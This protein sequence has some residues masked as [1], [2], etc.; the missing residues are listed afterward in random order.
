MKQLISIALLFFIISS[1]SLI[2]KDAVIIDHNCTDLDKIPSEFI[3]KSKNGF[4]LGYGHTSHGSQIVSGMNLLKDFDDLYSFN[5]GSGSLFLQDYISD[6]DY[7]ARD[8]G[9]PNFS[10]WAGSTFNILSDSNN[11]LNMIMWSWCGQVSGASKENID[12]YLSQ[13]EDLEEKFPE[14]TFVYMTG[15]L[16][17]SGLKG[18]LHQ[19]NEIIRKFCRDNKKV[20]FDF[21]D[22]ESYDPD[23]NYFLDKGANDACNYNGGNWAV[24]WCNG[25]PDK[26]EDCSCSHSHCLNCQQKGKAF[27]WM[28]ARVAGWDGGKTSFV[29][30]DT[31]NTDKLYLEQNVPNPVE[32]SQTVFKFYLPKEAF[33]T[34]RIFDINGNEVATV[35]NS[36]K[37]NSGWSEV[38]YGNIDKLVQGSYEYVIEAAG[39]V[40][41][42]RMVVMR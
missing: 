30:Q 37:Y 40:R 1:F 33:V 6:N 28:M 23:G 41:S 31:V 7:E 35:V 42:K 10:A 13:M 4:R 25:N 18:N 9:N 2:A 19:N 17:G 14:V 5:S 29:E 11:E 12:L 15:H 24:E 34:L 32:G 36:V 21:A 16:D 27:W 39:E 20:L 26:C 8:L 3:T 38:I 22:I